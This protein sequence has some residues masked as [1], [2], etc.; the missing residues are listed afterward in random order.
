MN[1]HT[2]NSNSDRIRRH[3]EY[4]AAQGIKRVEMK[5]PDRDVELMKSL[6]SVLQSGGEKAYQAR[7]A[8][9]A[10]IPHD[11]QNMVDFFR[12]SPLAEYND[13]L[14]LSRDKETGDPLTFD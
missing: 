9:L 10:I 11:K 5:V 3:R 7:N 6:A 12:N 14:D 13:E 8:V 4:V 1:K 2:E